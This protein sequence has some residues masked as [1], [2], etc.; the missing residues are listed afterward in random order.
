MASKRSPNKETVRE[1]AT[2]VGGKNQVKSK[3]VRSAAS[4]AGRP[5]KRVWT[6]GT[7]EY[8]VL[9]QRQ[10]GL[11][12]FFTKSRGLFPSYIVNSWR[13]LKLVSWPNRRTTWK[14][15]SAVFVFAII[16]GVTIALVDYGLEKVFKQILL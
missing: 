2:R 7:R 13:E 6:A 16:F 14:L 8:H 11:V 12:G 5:I 9:P 1:R 15:V 4:A 3:R 10:S